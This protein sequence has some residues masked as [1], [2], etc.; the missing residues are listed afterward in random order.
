M[1]DYGLEYK[2]AILNLV[3]KKGIAIIFDIHG[4]SNKYP[5]DIDIGT[6]NGI[7]INKENNILQAICELLSPLG[8]IGID[9]NFKASQDTTICN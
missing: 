4:C 7:N 9:E 5:Y 3:H 1:L 6:N 2:N 8:K